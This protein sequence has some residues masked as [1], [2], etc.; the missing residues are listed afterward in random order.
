MHTLIQVGCGA[1]CQ[2]TCKTLASRLHQLIDACWGD[3]NARDVLSMEADS[4][5]SNSIDSRVEVN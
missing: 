3:H 1:S 2:G 4:L 5:E